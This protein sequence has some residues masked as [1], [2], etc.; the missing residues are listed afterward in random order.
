LNVHAGALIIDWTT[1]TTTTASG[2]TIFQVASTSGTYTTGIAA[3]DTVVPNL[4]NFGRTVSAQVNSLGFGGG[5]TYALMGGVTFELVAQFSN[6]NDA[7]HWSGASEYVVNPG[8]AAVSGN[9]LYATSFDP[10]MFEYMRLLLRHGYTAG[11]SEFGTV[12]GRTAHK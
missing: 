6:I 7:A 5:M 10:G 3:G 4:T 1:S 12:T 2:D 9:S 8:G 11:T